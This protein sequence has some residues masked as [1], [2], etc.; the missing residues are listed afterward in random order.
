MNTDL[1]PLAALAR[2]ALRLLGQPTRNGVAA[3]VGVVALLY[4][5]AVTFFA[6][7]QPPVA[8]LTMY[9]QLVTRGTW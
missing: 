8:A 6:L 1:A 5:P 2:S 3:R 4:G 9:Y 7:V